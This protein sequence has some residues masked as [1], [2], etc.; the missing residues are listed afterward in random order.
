MADAKSVVVEWAKWFADNKHTH[1]FEYSESADRMNAIGQWPIRF[2]VT[3][4]C[5]AFVTLC[6]WLAGLPDPNHQHY[7]HEGYTGTLIANGQEVTRLTAEPGDIVIYGPET[8]WHT[9]IIVEAGS[10]PLTVSMGQNGDPSYVTTAQDGREPQRFFR[11][12]SEAVNP[13]HRPV[14]LVAKIATPDVV[15]GIAEP[16]PQPPVEPAHIQ[17][18]PEA[19]QTPLEAPLAPTKVEEVV[20]PTSG[21]IAKMEHLIEEIIEG[22]KE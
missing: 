14:T 15:K 10:N 19:T 11:F 17:S 20:I 13:I 16:K 22:P 12:N 4:D 1:P 5:S 6:Y 2:P 7:D 9:A 3:C 8:G 21:P 18:K